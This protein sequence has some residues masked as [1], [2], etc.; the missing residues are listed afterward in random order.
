MALSAEDRLRILENKVASLRLLVQMH[1]MA[2]DALVDGSAQLTLDLAKTQRDAALSVGKNPLAIGL[3][4]LIDDLAE[5]ND[6]QL[7]D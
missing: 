4:A 7:G 6:A 2:M 1:I 5:F 3:D